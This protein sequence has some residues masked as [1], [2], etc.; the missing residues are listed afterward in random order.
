MRCVFVGYATNSKACRLLK[1]ESNMIVESRDVE[2]F[3]NLLISGNRSQAPANKTL[4][5]R[6]LLL[7]GQK[8]NCYLMLY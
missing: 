4:R 6:I 1:L 8:W 3:D 2:F 5:Q 7:K